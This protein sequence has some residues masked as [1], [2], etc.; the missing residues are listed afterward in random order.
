MKKFTMRAIAVCLA[1]S[2]I[3]AI[4]VSV[5]GTPAGS[6]KSTYLFATV[7]GTADPSVKGWAKRVTSAIRQTNGSVLTSDAFE[8]ALLVPL[9]SVNL[10][11]TSAKQAAVSVV[12]S[13]GGSAYAECNLDLRTVLTNGVAEYKVAVKNLGGYLKA[14]YGVCDTNLTK[15]GI[16][17]GVPR[18]HIDD[19]VTA[20]LAGAAF[21]YGEFAYIPGVLISTQ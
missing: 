13:R 2:C 1:C 8:G 4:N 17:L 10:D 6:G 3:G 9:P 16:Q 21:A 18:V 5:A 7:K 11:L 12:L 19:Q 14:Y 20:E 15:G